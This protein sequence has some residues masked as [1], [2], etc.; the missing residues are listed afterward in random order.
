[1]NGNKPNKTNSNLV[2]SV[3]RMPFEIDFQANNLGIHYTRDITDK[4]YFYFEKRFL[5]RMKVEL[6]LNLERLFRNHTYLQDPHKNYHD[7]TDDLL[8][9]KTRSRPDLQPYC[10]FQ[11]T[12]SKVFLSHSEWLRFKG[13]IKRKGFSQKYR[14]VGWQ[15]LVYPLSNNRLAMGTPSVT[16]KIGRKLTPS[17]A[18]AGAPGAG[19]RRNASED[20]PTH[21]SGPFE[22][23]RH[24]LRQGRQTHLRQEASVPRR[25]RA[26]NAAGVQR[27][28]GHRGL[29][30]QGGLLPR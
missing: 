27:V 5:E 11:A 28:Q 7:I 9:P 1:M 19:R 14:F 12:I 8:D 15:S 17:Q 16:R 24:H 26:G 30:P 10:F 21:P 4:Q 18:Q 13:I 6:D 29:L 20:L 2:V 25:E 22:R 23:N 3:N